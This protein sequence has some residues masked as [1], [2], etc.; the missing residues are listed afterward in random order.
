MSWLELLCSNVKCLTMF[1]MPGVTLLM[2]AVVGHP[3]MCSLIRL[4]RGRVI[5]QRILASW[6]VIQ[7]PNDFPPNLHHTLS[8]IPLKAKPPLIAEI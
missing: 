7:V 8:T 4:G 3:K 1:K 5:C 2:L 6:G